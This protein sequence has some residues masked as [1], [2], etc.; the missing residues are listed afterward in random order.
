MSLFFLMCSER[1]G[2]NL[3]TK[4]MN[5][6]HK[7][8]GP[9]TKHIVNPVARNFFRYGDLTNEENWEALVTDIHNLIS[10][11]FS[12]WKYK[13]SCDALKGLAEPGDIKPLIHN[14]FMAEARANGKEHVFIKENQVYEFM[15]FLMTHFPNSKFVYQTRDPRDM[16]LSWKKSGNH[17][18]GVV[19][20]S[21]QW[22][23]DQQRSLMNYH[24][25]N[26]RKQCHF[27]TYENL[28]ENCEVE[29]RKINDFLEVPYDPHVFD[30][31]KDDMTKQNARIN[32]SWNNLGNHVMA[33]NKGKY[34]EELTH[35]EIKAIEK[36]CFYE[37]NQLGYT[38]C[39]SESELL[40]TPEW[41]VDRLN[42]SEMLEIKLDRSPGVVANM[43]AKARFYQRCS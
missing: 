29:V 31:Y 38:P 1:S 36:V 40:D 4:L 17:P 18:G 6:H 7:V 33:G 23:H 28:I 5:G 42:E 25:L 26:M 37:M 32:S 16:A 41:W 30:F 13:F 9:S 43:S 35:D 10:V 21:R 11:D 39:H 20:A 3:I 27:L 24:I 15:P 22:K 8:C 19:R 14:I 2:S 34:L 12:V